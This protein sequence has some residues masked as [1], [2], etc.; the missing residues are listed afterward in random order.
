M[1]KI[2]DEYFDDD[3]INEFDEKDVCDY[4]L[5]IHNKAQNF[6]R[7]SKMPPTIYLNGT[8]Y[9]FCCRNI[10][11]DISKFRQL[12]VLSS[13]DTTILNAYTAAWWIRRKPFQFKENCTKDFLYINESFAATLLFQSSN[14]YDKNGGGYTVDKDKLAA[15][16]RQIMNYLKFHQVTPQSLNLFLN[17]L[18]F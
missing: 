18:N 10:I 16:A 5:R 9:A 15:I 13:E 4:L 17:A 1:Y 11:A 2:F 8:S 6:L 3:L 14:L 12:Q 7:N